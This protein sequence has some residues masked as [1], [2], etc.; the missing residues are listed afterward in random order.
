MKPIN[1]IIKQCAA[2]SGLKSYMFARINEANYLMDDI[3]EYPVML[4][5]FN[6]SVTE[7]PNKIRGM[8]TR[9]T[10]LY[11][12]DLMGEVE[13]D[14]ETVT[15][16]IV[17]RMESAVFSFIESLRRMN[18]QVEITAPITPFVG[19]FDAL[20][21]GVQCGLRLSYSMPCSR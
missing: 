2:E 6:D 20:V 19:K 13:P 14:T 21:T 17:E 18:V 1:E 15:L 4:R 9:T 7:G 10:T 8:Q 12:C 11:F 5:Q 16:P 3:K